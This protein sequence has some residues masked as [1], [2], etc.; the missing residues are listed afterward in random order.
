M[1]SVELLCASLGI[2]WRIHELN[3]KIEDMDYQPENK[4]DYE[5]DRVDE[6]VMFYRN[7]NLKPKTGEFYDCIRKKKIFD[8]LFDW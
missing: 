1:L 4:L 2:F 3:N 7:E 5:R 6:I 8:V